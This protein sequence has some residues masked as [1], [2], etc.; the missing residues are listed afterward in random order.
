MSAEEERAR[1]QREREERKIKKDLENFG[2]FVS[3]PTRA[4]RPT[5]P[6]RHEELQRSYNELK[7]PEK[8]EIEVKRQ[9]GGEL[10]GELG[11]TI[12]LTV[13]HNG[14]FQVGDF[15]INGALRDP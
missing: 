12:E 3:D 13:V 11:D 15:Y 14:E 7:A 1:M 6:K 5:N 2:R 8:R 4:A 9:A 10:G